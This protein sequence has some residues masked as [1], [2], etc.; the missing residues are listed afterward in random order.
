MNIW[1]DISS[2]GG[3]KI[4][5]S[6]DLDINLSLF[7]PAKIVKISQQIFVMSEMHFESGFYIIKGDN[8]CA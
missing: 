5:S 2:A 3:R 6:Q 1:G 7:D 8:P 4:F